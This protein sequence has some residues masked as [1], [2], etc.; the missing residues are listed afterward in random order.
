MLGHIVSKGKIAPDS[1]KVDAFRRLQEPRN[2][3]QLRAFLGLGGFYRRFIARF[4]KIAAPLFK[5]LQKDA[6]WD[7]GDL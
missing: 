7:W 3:K 4:A 6:G 5:L 2:L 1:E